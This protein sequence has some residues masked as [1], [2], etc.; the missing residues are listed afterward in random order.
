MT[1]I[2]ANANEP[3]DLNNVPNEIEDIRYCVLDYSDPKNPDYFFIPL[4]FL[5]SFFAPAVVLK[6]GE[7]TVQMPLDWSILVCDDSYSDMELMPLT[8][9]ND[10]GFHTLAFNPLKHMVP[11]PQEISITNVYSEVKWYFPKLKNGNILVVPVEDK[12]CPACVL[13]VKEVNK[14]PDVIGIGS[15]FE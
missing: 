7:F 4:I 14:L 12:P 5:E 1:Q 6:I 9:L 10:R 11:R 8:S 13:F 3:Y 15:L 2:F